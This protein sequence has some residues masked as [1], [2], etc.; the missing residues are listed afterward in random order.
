[1]TSGHY[2]TTS[3]S[4]ENWEALQRHLDSSPTWGWREYSITTE[5]QGQSFRVSDTSINKINTI[6]N[7]Y[8]Y[9]STR[10]E[11]NVT[12]DVMGL[13]T[14]NSNA[15][16]LSNQMDSDLDYYFWWRALKF[17]N[18]GIPVSIE[19]VLVEA[20]L[21]FVAVDK[22][23]NANPPIDGTPNAFSPAI[24]NLLKFGEIIQIDGVEYML[25]DMR[26]FTENQDSGNI[27]LPY[28]TNV[29]TSIYNR[30][31]I[32]SIVGAVPEGFELVGSVTH[33]G[34]GNGTIDGNFKISDSVIAKSDGITIKYQIQPI[35][36]G[37]PVKDYYKNGE[38]DVP[39]GHTYFSVTAV[40]ETKDF[41]F[42]GDSVDVGPATTHTFDVPPLFKID[43]TI[44]AGTNELNPDDPYHSKIIVN[45]ESTLTADITLLG[46]TTV[47]QLAIPQAWK[48]NYEKLL[49]GDTLTFAH[50]LSDL[51]IALKSVA[52]I[53]DTTTAI[54]SGYP[55]GNHYFSATAYLYATGLTTDTPSGK[56]A[57]QTSTNNQY[58][59]G[60]VWLEVIGGKLI[61]RT[62]WAE[63]DDQ[64]AGHNK[65]SLTIAD[66]KVFKDHSSF[67]IASVIATDQ[68]GGHDKVYNGV[69][70]A[71]DYMATV[72]LPYGYYAISTDN[73]G[74][75]S[76][77][78]AEG[79]GSYEDHDYIIIIKITTKML[80]FFR[81]CSDGGGQ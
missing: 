10:V 61:I 45:K 77:Q 68:T 27:T 9:N 81:D 38:I 71:E 73:N 60:C 49:K 47:D 76:A 51:S 6:I 70:D 43:L 74:V 32:N 55:V 8:D 36:A 50:E 56:Y 52:R 63:A 20:E 54:L 40:H 58:K 53:T 41:D 31:K 22:K 11:R 42:H 13:N 16:I 4:V 44:D 5:K 79:I 80:P 39:G 59:D 69:A 57:E 34:V 23:G 26:D 48:D 14:G 7:Q 78:S 75:Y 67:H 66:V 64:E 17:D 2:I 15:I 21:N 33:T 3:T 46:N 35:D 72:Y 19:D 1:M 29:F 24:A 25:I 62:V 28:A 37:D 18:N 12:Q 65:D 30:A